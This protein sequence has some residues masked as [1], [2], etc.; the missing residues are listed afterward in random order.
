M[1]HAAHACTRPTLAG[2][3]SIDPTNRG[4]GEKEVA[5]RAGDASR[6]WL[7]EEQEEDVYWIFARSVCTRERTSSAS[8]ALS[9]PASAR[10]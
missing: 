4:V 5:A 1:A 10:N 3:V 7:R 2:S 9:D 8:A 6:P